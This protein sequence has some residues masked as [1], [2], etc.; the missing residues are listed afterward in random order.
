MRSSDCFLRANKTTVS[1]PDQSMRFPA[2]KQLD[3]PRNMCRPTASRSRHFPRHRGGVHSY[4]TYFDIVDSPQSRSFS[5][6]GES[7]S[8]RALNDAVKIPLHS[9]ASGSRGGKTWSLKVIPRLLLQQSEAEEGFQQALNQITFERCEL[10]LGVICGLLAL[11]FG[12][13]FLL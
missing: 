10:V 11:E 8:G 7:R 13:T 3:W 4:L 12:V 2:Q 5:C 9:F 1:R 6:E